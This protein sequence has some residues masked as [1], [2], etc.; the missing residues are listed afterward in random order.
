M[1]GS[2][3]TG[4]IGGVVGIVVFMY[5]G[6]FVAAIAASIFWIVEL[7]DVARRQFYDPNMK[8]V[9]VVVLIFTHFIGSLIYYFVGKGQGYL[10]GQQPMM[11]PDGSSWPPPP[12]G[13]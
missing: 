2:D 11:R 3:P 13:Y 10:P 7:I 5:I 8:I 12:G 9:W 4:V 1:S 6:I